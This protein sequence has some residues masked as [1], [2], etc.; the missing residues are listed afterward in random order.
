MRTVRRS[1]RAP[2][3]HIACTTCDQAGGGRRR[4]LLVLLHVRRNFKRLLCR[5]RGQTGR[6]AGAH[7]IAYWR[8]PASRPRANATM[9]CPPCTIPAVSSHAPANS[10]CGCAADMLTIAVTRRSCAS[11]PLVVAG[12]TDASHPD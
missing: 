8:M 3:Q 5:R 2:Q 11:L 4:K 9:P 7:L 10:T 1:V 6:E 12:A